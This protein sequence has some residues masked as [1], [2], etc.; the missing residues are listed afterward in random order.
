[1]TSSVV[2]VSPL[3]VSFVGGG[4]DISDFYK[5]YDGAVVSCAIRKYVYV[6]AK[7]HDDSFGERYRISYSKVEHAIERS[8]IENEIV[9][10]CLELLD[11]QDP[12]QISTLSDLPAGTGLGSS[13]S[14]TAAVL[15][16]L[17]SL[18][19][20]IPSK[21]QLAEEACW[22]EI[23]ILK[24]PIG[25]QDQYASVF[26]G[27][28]LLT[29]NS[30]YGVKVKAIRISKG[31]LDEFMRRSRLFW[32]GIRRE[33]NLVLTDQRSRS[34]QNEEALQRMSVLA[35]LFHNILESEA[36]NWRRLASVLRDSW[37]LKKTLSPLIATPDLQD[38]I[39]TLETSTNCG[40]KI[41]GAGGGGFVY[42]ID[43]SSNES[44]W[45]H[46]STKHHSFSPE[47]DY[48]GTRVISRF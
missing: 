19:G 7:R 34:L 40:V 22:V 20:R 26:G 36:V 13:S 25:K 33:A 44:I 5:L 12:I 15:M 27:L 38:F 16:S 18:E 4:T 14:F 43:G 31:N 39:A 28:N 8:K 23:E 47:I 32:T 3:R 29:F 2:T 46:Q 24:R 35:L 21:Q 37:Q 6:H 11:F 30:Q 41:L 42:A 1:M 9:R 10:S 17:H 45:S 48:E